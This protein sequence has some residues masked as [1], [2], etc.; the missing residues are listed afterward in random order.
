MRLKE[1]MWTQQSYSLKLL[2]RSLALSLTLTSHTWSSLFIINMW[3]ANWTWS[4][5]GERESGS[6]IT[7][8]LCTSQGCCVTATHTTRLH[9]TANLICC[10]LLSLATDLNFFSRLVSPL[11]LLCPCQTRQGSI[12]DPKI[13]ALDVLWETEIQG[14]YLV[15]H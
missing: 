13:G 1:R 4:K 6:T 12:G 11:C 5:E 9:V 7:S 3:R 2:T 15:G 14:V 8:D 10:S